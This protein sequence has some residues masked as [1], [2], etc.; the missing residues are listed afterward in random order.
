MTRLFELS[1]VLSKTDLCDE[2]LLILFDDLP[3]LKGVGLVSSVRSIP[4]TD[5]DL[6]D[7]DCLPIT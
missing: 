7:T 4:I 3:L 1:R 6:E 2:R 5:L